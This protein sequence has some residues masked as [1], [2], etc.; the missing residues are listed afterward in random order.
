MQTAIEAFTR[1][2]RESIRLG[3]SMP[4]PY[5]RTEIDQVVLCGPGSET[6]LVQAI[7]SDEARVPVIVAEGYSLPAF[8]SNHTLVITLSQSGTHQ[9]VLSLTGEAVAKNAGIAC[10]TGGGP[11]S[12]LAREKKCFLA[13][14][15]P[16]PVS[17]E[18]W[19]IHATVQLLF[20]LHHYG[21]IGHSFLPRL[22]KAIKLIDEREDIIREGA[23]DIA[24]A[25]AGRLTVL[26]GSTRLY[27][28]MLHFRQQI[29]RLAR[30]LAHVNVFPATNYDEVAAWE[31]PAALIDQSVVIFFESEFDHPKVK[32]SID[33]CRPI[34]SGKTDAI[35]EVTMRYGDSFTEQCLYM[36]HLADWAAYYLASLNQ[37]TGAEDV[38]SY[39][40]T[41][42][43]KE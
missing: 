8:V 38:P 19:R 1:Q 16:G 25:I 13:P 37:A 23:K 30:Q 34:F 40:Q 22:E 24:E 6:V 41:E 3:E 31:H 20:L 2:L 43:D 18:E 26:Y 11:L 7:V 21:L 4:P 28:V 33:I 9:E 14:V 32:R 27:P 12:E 15:P 42:L 35:V 39:V 10:I 36:I 5:F 17:P 29:N